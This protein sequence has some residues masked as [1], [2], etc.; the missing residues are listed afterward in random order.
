MRHK[1]KMDDVTNSFDKK[2]R[3]SRKLFLQL[4]ALPENSAEYKNK[5]NELQAVDKEIQ[6]LLKMEF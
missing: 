2:A 5:M 1:I 6:V 3:Q 4:S